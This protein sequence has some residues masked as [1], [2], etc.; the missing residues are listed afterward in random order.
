MSFQNFIPTVCSAQMLTALKNDNV[1]VRLSDARYRADA[2][3]GAEIKIN[4]VGRVAIRDYQ[5]GEPLVRDGWEDQS[6]MIRIDQQK[7]FNFGVDDIDKRQAQGDLIA[8]LREEAKASLADAADSYVYSLQ[9]DAG[10]RIQQQTV[11]AGNVLSTIT[12][13]IKG[14]YKNKVPKNAQF[15]LEV[16]PDFLEKMLLADILYGTP[17][18]DSMKN[19]F[20]GRVG[21]WLNVHVYMTNNLS[22][23]DGQD[24]I[25][26]RTKRAIAFVDN[27]S[28][29]EAYRPEDSFE[30][31][32]KGLHVYGAKVVRPDELAVIQC[33]YGEETK[34]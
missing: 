14:L 30:D 12:S 31:A 9:G 22:Q 34:I 5:K 16:S 3:Y 19:G 13:A 20:V 21:K 4:G 11:T 8:A 10:V 27:M 26:L 33:G 2:K 28:Q 23:Q 29:V 18:E 25:F 1:A 7:Y 32:L 15:S 24:C 17:N 6:T